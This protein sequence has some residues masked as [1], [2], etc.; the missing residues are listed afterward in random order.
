MIRAGRDVVF[1]PFARDRA[2]P[3]PIGFC[4]RHARLDVVR[5]A[6]KQCRELLPRLFEVSGKRGLQGARLITGAPGAF[7]EVQ[8]RLACRLQCHVVITE[9]AVRARK[10]HPGQGEPGILRHSL[11]KGGTPGTV[12][13]L[14]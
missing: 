14:K 5:I 6:R 8:N 11:F 9:C 7:G 1:S 3:L 13:P 4:E 10:L 2:G 12:S